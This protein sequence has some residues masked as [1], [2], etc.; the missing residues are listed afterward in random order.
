MILWDSDFTE[1][2]TKIERNKVGGEDREEMEWGRYWV[3]E[4]YGWEDMGWWR[5]EK[6]EV[7][8]WIFRYLGTA[9][10]IARL[11]TGNGFAL[12]V[13]ALRVL[14]CGCPGGFVASNIKPVFCDQKYI[15]IK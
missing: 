8:I 1:N 4:R 11:G 12:V 9:A 3:K 5:N 6:G 14:N 7:T 2:M 15:F 10:W 13:T